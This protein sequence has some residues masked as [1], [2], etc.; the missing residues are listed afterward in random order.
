MTFN[1]QTEVKFFRGYGY[2]ILKSM[3][4]GLIMEEWKHNMKYTLI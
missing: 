4:N 3:V 1:K 2:F